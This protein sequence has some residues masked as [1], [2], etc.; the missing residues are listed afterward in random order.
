MQL[1]HAAALSD[2]LACMKLLLHIVGWIFKAIIGLV[3]FVA[4]VIVLIPNVIVLASQ[5]GNIVTAEKAA[6]LEADA[7]L[8]LGASVQPDGTPSTILQDRLDTAIDLY[9]QG[10]ASKIIMSGD[11]GD[12]SYNEPGA[13]KVYAIEQGVPS[14]DIFCDRAG[15]DTYDSMYR[16]Q[17]IFG[18]EKLIVVTQSYHLPRALFTANV[19]GMKAEG[20]ASDVRT[21]E[22][23]TWYDVREVFARVK[24]FAQ[25]IIR[26]PASTTSD[27]PVSLSESGDVTNKYQ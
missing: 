10:V 18:V 4:V 3:L 13:M 23:Q 24:D 26:R 16:A 12:S 9:K 8:V 19:L 25:V 21:Y 1:S 27:S 15:F 20:V 2:I 17:S 5:G 22:K 11:G 7:I 14:E 6:D